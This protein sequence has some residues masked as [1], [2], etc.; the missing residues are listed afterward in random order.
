M[1]PGGGEP[2]LHRVGLPRT[3]VLL[4]D[5]SGVEYE[6]TASLTLPA[7]I[8]DALPRQAQARSA[9]AVRYAA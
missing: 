3:N 8:L 9:I 2:R 5:A 7:R 4:T 6:W 1:V